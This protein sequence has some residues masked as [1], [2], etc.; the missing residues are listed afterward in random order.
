MD[1]ELHCG[2]PGL[3][4]ESQQYPGSARCKVDLPGSFDHVETSC[5]WNKLHYLRLAWTVGTAF[6]ECS[7]FSKQN[8]PESLAISIRGPAHL[9]RVL[10]SKR[11]RIHVQDEPSRIRPNSSDPCMPFYPSHW[12]RRKRS[13]QDTEAGGKSCQHYRALGGKKVLRRFRSIRNP[14]EHFVSS[15]HRRF[16]M[17]TNTP[18]WG[19]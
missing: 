15:P 7:L 3:Q 19:G 2:I 1:E 11:A 9:A 4:G 12:A 13:E 10:L 8:N 17:P 16:K 14:V 5:P 18:R 6:S